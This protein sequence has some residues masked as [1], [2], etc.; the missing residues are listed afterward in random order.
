MK[1]VE[2]RLQQ[3]AEETRQVAGAHW[4]RPLE[5]ETPERRQGWLVFAAAFALVVVTFGLVP[6]L[7]GIGV[8]PPVGDSTL[9]VEPV[10]TSSTVTDTTLGTAPERS[11][12]DVPLPG[13]IEGLPAAVAEKRDAIIA[14]AASCDIETLQRLAADPFTTSYGWGGSENLVIWNDKGLEPTKTLL[15]L[16]DMR[17]ATVE[18]E[19]GS[20][21][22]WPAALTYESWNETTEKERNELAQIHSEGELDLFAHGEAY[23][24]WRVG[25]DEDGNWLYFV[26]GD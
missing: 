12:P 24:G 9:P 5:S 15:L 7:A 4:P 2:Q 23:L 14:A 1:S 19:N 6:W 25:I 10:A 21:Y 17:Y 22:V 3:A 18:G 16:L 11:C 13:Q 20:I 26:A 8:E